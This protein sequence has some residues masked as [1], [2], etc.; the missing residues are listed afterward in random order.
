MKIMIFTQ[1][2]T[3]GIG[4]LQSLSSRLRRPG[5]EYMVEDD[6]D[7]SFERDRTVKRS[8][9]GAT[10]FQQRSYSMQQETSPLRIN[11]EFNQD[12]NK[13]FSLPLKKKFGHAQADIDPEMASSAVISIRA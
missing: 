8:F 9:V 11:T 5:I 7:G 3:L 1:K 4:K 13:L 12:S 6:N 10:K 2:S